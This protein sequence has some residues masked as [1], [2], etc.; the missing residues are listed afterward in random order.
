MLASGVSCSSKSPW[1]APVVLVRKKSGELRFCIDF[2]RLNEVTKK[3]AYP[4]PRIDDCLDALEGSKFFSTLDLASGY[5]QV[6]MVESDREKMAF[7]THRGLFE[8]VVMPLWL[9][10]APAT[11][12]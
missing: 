8:W 5:W 10:N 12:F 1:G 2:R 7:I 3:D 11:F 6:A 4:L 9:C